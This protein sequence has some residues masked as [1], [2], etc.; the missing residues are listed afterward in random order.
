MNLLQNA[1]GLINILNPSEDIYVIRVIKTNVDGIMQST[2][3]K[4]QTTAQIQQEKSQ[5]IQQVNG[6]FLNG[7]K[8]LTFYI[9]G[10]LANVVNFLEHYSDG[11]SIIEYRAK[12]YEIVSKTSWINN[13]WIKVTGVLNDN[14]PSNL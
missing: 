11:N 9:N 8:Y 5:D 3:E 2:E 14:I 4:I 7:D 12:R 6:M 10:D 13:G 1:I